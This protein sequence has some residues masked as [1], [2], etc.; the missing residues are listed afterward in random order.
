MR[1]LTIFVAL[2]FAPLA[3][4]AASDGG[5]NP[6]SGSDAAQQC[7]KGMVWHPQ[8]KKCVVPKNSGLS[9]DT[10]YE[11]VRFLSYDG[12]HGDAL[13]LLDAMQDQQDDRHL[14]YRGF[15]NRM[16]GNR[17]VAREWYDRALKAN[18]DNFL[19]RS[20]LGQGMVSD[21]N[22]PGAEK[23][24]AEIRA[25]GGSGSWAETSLVTAIATG[26][27]HRY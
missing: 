27:I 26:V 8:A 16:L 19:A 18:P 20:Y 1:A 25:R 21:G 22:I 11:T 24:L 9:D 2:A 13:A 10:V 15:N 12:Q 14:T 3:A 4:H 5:S 7:A 17:A 6:P 23:Q